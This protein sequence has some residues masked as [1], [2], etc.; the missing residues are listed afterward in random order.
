MRIVHILQGKAK[1]DSLNGVNKVVHWM[2][3]SQAQQG[4]DVEVWGLAVS[5]NLPPHP[6]EYNLRLFPMRRLRVTLGPEIKMAISRLEPGTWVHFHLAFTPELPTIAQLVKKRGLA[7]GVTPHGIYALGGLKKSPWK[8]RLWIAVRE[9]KYLRNAAW[10]QAIG[11]SEVQEILRI[12]PGARVVLIP[13][14][15]EPIPVRVGAVP[16]N[17]ERPLIGFCGR[18]AMEHKGLDYL[19]EGFAAYKA[20][21]GAGELWLIGEGKDRAQLERQA[22][23]NGAAPNVLFLGAKHGEEKFDLVASVDA[24]IHSSRWDVLPGACMEAAALGRPLLVSRE[25]NMAEYV[26]RSGAGLVLE[27]TSAVGVARV[28]ERVQRLY[29]ANQLQQMGENARGLIEKEF[30]W[31]ENARRFVAAIAPSGSTPAR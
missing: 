25:T 19:I 9:A 24:F 16:A 7:Y 14:C 13:N 11:A 20:K 8:K 27:E 17:A 23:K 3:T 12:A 15:Q 18:L 2:A 1:P 30:R 6:R 22:A 28:L 5:M 21:G 29:E 31:E 4:H 26:E 10:I